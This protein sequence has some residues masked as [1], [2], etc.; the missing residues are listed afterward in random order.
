MRISGSLVN[1]AFVLRGWHRADAF[2]DYRLV[3]SS[4]G[5]VRAL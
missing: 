2:A 3:A 4:A 1:T 5:P